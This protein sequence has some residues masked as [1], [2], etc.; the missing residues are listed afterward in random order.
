MFGAFGGHDVVGPTGSA[1]FGLSG[2]RH[3]VRASGP[4]RRVEGVPGMDVCASGIV[5][6]SARRGLGF[7]GG[8]SVHCDVVGA[9]GPEIWSDGSRPE[10]RSDEVGALR[11]G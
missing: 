2:R 6:W 9:S 5:T 4:E 3:V 8:P 1:R 7:R 11:R 10:R